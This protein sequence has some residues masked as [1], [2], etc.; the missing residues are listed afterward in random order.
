MVGGGVSGF[1]EEEEEATFGDRDV[2]M[3]SPPPVV[4]AG[5]NKRKRVKSVNG[6]SIIISLLWT[7]V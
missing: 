5:T 3:S 1:E 4:E 2:A 7:F 6:E